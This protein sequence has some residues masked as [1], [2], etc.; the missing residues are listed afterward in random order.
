MIKEQNLIFEMTSTQNGNCPAPLLEEIKMLKNRVERHPT[1]WV[2]KMRLAEAL[3]QQADTSEARRLYQEIVAADPGGVFA[4]RL[5]PESRSSPASWAS[6]N[7][8][9]SR[10]RPGKSPAPSPVPPVPNLLWQRFANLPV[11]RKLLWVLLGAKLV[12]LPLLFM[13]S[14]SVFK[15]GTEQQVLRQVEARAGAL[16]EDTGSQKLVAGLISGENPS[17]ARLPAAGAAAAGAGS[18]T[19]VY[20]RDGSG[21]FIL[22]SSREEVKGTTRAGIS[23]PN[24]NLL[25]KAAAAKGETVTDWAS[26]DG[27]PYAMAAVALPAAA[28]APKPVLVVGSDSSEI[29]AVLGTSLAALL[30]VAL[31][32]LAGELLLAR[33]LVKAIAEPVEQLRKGAAQ[34]SAGDS[35][36]GRDSLRSAAAISKG[37]DEC[38]ELAVA[39]SELCDEL[40][41]STAALEEETR[42]RQAEAALYLREKQRLQQEVSQLL[43]DIAGAFH[44]DLALSC[45]AGEASE[46][47]DSLSVTIEILRQIVSQVVSAAFEIRS[48]AG[49]SSLEGEKLSQNSQASALATALD[50][51]AE[52]NRSMRSV[53]CT[54]LK[55]ASIVSQAMMAAKEGEKRINQTAIS[56][57]QVRES[58]TRAKGVVKRQAESSQ[59]IAK[60]VSTIA[61]ISERTNLLAFNVSIAAAR[62]GYGGQVAAS[63]RSP[64]HLVADEVQRLAERV[65][66]EAIEI[67]QLVSAIQQGT[68]EALQTMEESAAQVETGTELLAKTQLSLR[69]LAN[70]NHKTNQLLQSISASTVSQAQASARVL[71]IQFPGFNSNKS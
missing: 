56:V 59:E 69:R 17:K 19:A 29:N 65:R 57:S 40:S 71:S 38:S 54:T 70:M 30:G 44:G 12:S 14:Y 45:P 53:A 64:L 9:L 60:I 33:V 67:E 5:K 36:A 22:A 68:L 4:G 37:G 21:E 13:V 63:G 55:A 25:K 27:R 6:D 50:S 47:A 58:L 28:G 2:A 32:V 48:Q 24:Q 34:I 49:N 35:A 39:L 26:I 41:Y 10:S 18:Y 3:T 20:L 1:D 52:M 61:S 51:V 7:G 62:A 15:A 31:L 66:A 46:M 42:L 11:R 43:R 16:A 23:L 8:Q